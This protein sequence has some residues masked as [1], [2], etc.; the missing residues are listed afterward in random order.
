MDKERLLLSGTADQWLRFWS[1]EN[2]GKLVFTLH[3]DHP[4]DDALSSI[5]VTQNN[6][7]IL[8]ADTSGLLKKWDF[9]MFDFNDKACSRDDIKVS[10]FIHAHKQ[11]INRYLKFN[12]LVLQ[13][14]RPSILFSL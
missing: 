11:I 5:A 13:L 12:L 1:T 3:A 9:T 8:T 14:L 4:K 2:N 7:Y 6:D 10:W